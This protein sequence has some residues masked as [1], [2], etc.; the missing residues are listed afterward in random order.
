MAEN[1]KGILTVIADNNAQTNTFFALLETGEL[2]IHVDSTMGLTR[3]TTE[4][5]EQLKQLL[6][7]QPI[8][9]AYRGGFLNANFFVTAIKL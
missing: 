2:D 3:L 1:T 5:V 8:T 6:N 9:L 7:T 4:Q